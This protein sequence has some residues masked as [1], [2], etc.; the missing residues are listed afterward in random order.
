MPSTLTLALACSV[1]W[2]AAAPSVCTLWNTGCLAWYTCVGSPLTL[3]ALARLLATVLS[4][5]DSAL[6]PEPAISNT[7]NEDMCFALLADD[8]GHQFLQTRTEKGERGQ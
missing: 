1:I 5:T 2:L 3:S 4:L 6:M 7:L 8:R